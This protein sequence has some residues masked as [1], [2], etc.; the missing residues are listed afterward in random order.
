MNTYF[1]DLLFRSVHY[2]ATKR[3]RTAAGDATV[4]KVRYCQ[5]PGG[6]TRHGRAG[7]VYSLPWWHCVISQDTDAQSARHTV[8]SA[9]VPRLEVRRRSAPV[10]SDSGADESWKPGCDGARPFVGNQSLRHHAG[11]SH[12]PHTTVRRST[13][14]R[15]RIYIRKSLKERSQVKWNMH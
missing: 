9:A 8:K 12:G 11:R 6:I 10:L 2:F 15:L 7:V 5:W 1:F 3:I 13:L 14:I 4:I